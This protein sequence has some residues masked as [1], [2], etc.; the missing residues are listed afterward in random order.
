MQ[1]QKGADGCEKFWRQNGVCVRERESAE[2]D[3]IR[4]CVGVQGGRNV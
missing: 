4:E 1:K 2:T 3:V